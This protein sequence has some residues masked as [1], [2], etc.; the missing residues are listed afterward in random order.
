M[1]WP[2]S[3]SVALAII[4]ISSLITAM[5]W[6]PPQK[7]IDPA[8]VACSLLLAGATAGSA[9]IFL[10]QTSHQ[11]LALLLLIVADLF[12]NL[13]IWLLRGDDDH[14]GGGPEADANGPDWGLFDRERQ[15][16]RSRER[17]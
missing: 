16:W 14:G 3:V 10:S 15:R 17:V 6:P 9:L 8:L 7:R 5:L 12:L 1:T 13:S 11:R 2:T 4:G